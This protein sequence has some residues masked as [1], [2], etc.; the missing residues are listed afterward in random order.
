MIL[1]ANS[2]YRSGL[3]RKRRYLEFERS[4]QLLDDEIEKLRSMSD[5]SLELGD[6]IES[7]ER[8]SKKLL[9]SISTS[10]S[11]YQVVQLS[12]HPDRPTTLDFVQYLADDF[13]ELRGDRAFSDDQAVVGGLASFSG[14]T[15]MMLGHQK[16]KS[17]A[18]NQMRN[19][20]MPRPEGY[21]KA[22]RLMKLAEQWKIPV[23]TWIDTPGAYPGLDAEERGQAEAI[24]RNI[25]E[26]SGLRVPIISVVIGEG[27]SGGALAIAVSDRLL[28]FQY[29]TY[30]VI[31]PEG[32]AA[33]TWKDAAKASTAAQALK[34]SAQDAL[35][36]GICDVIVKEPLGGAHRDF[37]SAA[38]S[39][40]PILE[41]ELAS[42]VAVDESQLIIDRY[43]RL[44]S[45]GSPFRG[46]AESEE[47]SART[48]ST[49]NKSHLTGVR[50]P[51]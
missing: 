21:R 44:R 38:Q 10:L 31:S 50:T 4:L 9:E 3:M 2:V 37:V 40:K 27:G 6:E 12:R 32:C 49:Q 14:T 42:L 23:I 36:F 45:Q 41:R 16:G 24:A 25:M 34:L 46:L 11:A 18:E 7:L 5:P 51:R 19:F 26:M 1:R 48:N 29:A 30:S 33:I 47:G 17:T 43:N 8:K 39:L 22:L 20:G 13:V 28:M 15:V 35:A